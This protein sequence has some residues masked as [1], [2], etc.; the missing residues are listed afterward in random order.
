MPTLWLYA[1]DD[2]GA[3][4]EDVLF[5]SRIVSST[6]TVPA[7]GTRIRTKGFHDLLKVALIPG[8]TPIVF[9]RKPSS[10]IFNP[11]AG[12]SLRANRTAIPVRAPP[13]YSHAKS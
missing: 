10:C 4:S 7:Y 12:L 13:S 8:E 2:P 5:V 6:S 1:G 3:G 11:D 9:A